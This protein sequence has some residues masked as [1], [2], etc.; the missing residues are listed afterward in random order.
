MVSFFQCYPSDD[1]L[2]THEDLKEIYEIEGDMLI[3]GIKMDLAMG[4]CN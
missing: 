3:D 1:L 4:D 2:F